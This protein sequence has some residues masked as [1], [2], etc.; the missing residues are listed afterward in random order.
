MCKSLY[1]H[2]GYFTGMVRYVKCIDSMCNASNCMCTAVINSGEGY[3][4]RLPRL[5]CK[6]VEQGPIHW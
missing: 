5:T 6:S 3:A 4:N 2:S 1:L